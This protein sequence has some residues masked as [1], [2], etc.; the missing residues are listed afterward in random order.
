ML[1]NIQLSRVVK[2]TLLFYL[3]LIS[4]FCFPFTYTLTTSS[5]T[6]H[7]STISFVFI[8]HYIF[9]YDGNGRVSNYIHGK[10]T[11]W[12]PNSKWNLFI[13]YTHVH[14]HFHSHRISAYTVYTVRTQFPCTGCPISRATCWRHLHCKPYCW[15]HLMA[16]P[17]LTLFPLQALCWHHL[18]KAVQHLS[19]LNVVS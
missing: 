14:P 8:S 3:L 19:Q 6:L 9:I 12:I 15:R 11:F 17:M 10:P 7:S 5:P 13:H 18:P 2:V 1:H 4:P 16:N